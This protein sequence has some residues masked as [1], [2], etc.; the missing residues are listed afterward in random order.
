MKA[1][2]DEFRKLIARA[3][4]TV[5][6]PVSGTMMDGDPE[7][8]QRLAETLEVYEWPEG[9]PRPRI[10]GSDRCLGELPAPRDPIVVGDTLLVPARMFGEKFAMVVPCMVLERVRCPTADGWKTWINV[11]RIDEDD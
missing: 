4:R 2:M 9:T 6:D 8:A 1:N 11:R 5:Y 3:L 7:K 10:S